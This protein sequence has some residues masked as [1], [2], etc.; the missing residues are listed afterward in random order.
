MAELKMGLVRQDPT[1]L[2]TT[3][4]LCVFLVLNL[5]VR[6]QWNGLESLRYPQG[7]VEQTAVA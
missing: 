1:N 5:Y 3:M 4:Q 7:S 2:N 6:L